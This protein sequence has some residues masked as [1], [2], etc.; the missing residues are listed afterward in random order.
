MFSL[1]P[2]TVGSQHDPPYTNDQSGG[3][4]NRHATLQ[5]KN[6]LLDQAITNLTAKLT[7]SKNNVAAAKLEAQAQAKNHRE[8]LKPALAETMKATVAK[9]EAERRMHNTYFKDHE[10]GCVHAKN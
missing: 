1:P 6:L 3:C 8:M 4:P 5:A 2:A 7:T 10:E 9:E